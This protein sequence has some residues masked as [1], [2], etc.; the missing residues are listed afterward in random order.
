[1]SYIERAKDDG[2]IT[3]IIP[4]LKGLA[5]QFARFRWYS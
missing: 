3:I 4:K 5:I 2:E 1:M